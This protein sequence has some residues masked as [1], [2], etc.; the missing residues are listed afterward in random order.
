MNGP[1]RLG[2]RNLAGPATAR[3]AAA[4]SRP[5]RRGGQAERV[6]AGAGSDGDGDRGGAL[7]I[8][9]TSRHRYPAGGREGTGTRANPRATGGAAII[10]DLLAKGLAEL[11]HQVSYHLEYGH[12]GPAP[13]GV[14]FV[15]APPAEVD[16]HHYYNSWFLRIAATVG[17]LAARE[18]PWIVS[19]HV[20][21][22]ATPDAGPGHR[23]GEVPANWVMVSRTLSALYG[24][25]RFVLNG[26][27]PS[28]LAYSASKEDYLLFA[29]RAEAAE[30]KGIGLA[31]EL[32]RVAGLRLVVVAS[33]GG[34]AAMEAMRRRCRQDGVE[35]VGDVRGA[36]K[37]ELF[38]GA[39]ALLFPT[40]I[41]EAFGLVIAE[42]LM[43]GTPVIASDRGACPELVTPDVGF[44]CET[45]DDYLRAI[46]RIG[47]IRPEACRARA[48][49]EFHYVRMA[50]EYLREYRVEIENHRVGTGSHDGS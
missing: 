42:A 38:A 5:A 22:T 46:D 8:L 24:H 1:P 40:Q 45:R 10:H 35:L 25:G 44:I 33:S 4:H 37:A 43:S 32:A 31:M 48:M 15:D 16:I 41:N 7:R 17:E 47:D 30:S 13:E 12:D 23:R 36:R 26:V 27:D 49:A 29:G 6:A 39:R 28:A 19:C 20:D 2:S 21:G 9:L 50:R 14:R 34:D 3:S 18:V 11:G